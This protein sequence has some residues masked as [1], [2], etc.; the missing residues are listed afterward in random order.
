MRILLHILAINYHE[1]HFTDATAPLR[2]MLDVYKYA[3]FCNPDFVRRK[4]LA[5]EFTVEKIMV[6]LNFL[7]DRGIIS[8]GPSTKL[9]NLNDL[10]GNEFA[11]YIQHC[12]EE[13]YSDLNVK[14]KMVVMANFWRVN[15]QFPAWTRLAQ[16]MMLLQPTS[17]AAERAFS[18][19]VRL[20]RRPGMD[21]AL[22]DNIE[23]TLMLMYNGESAAEELEA[24]EDDEDDDADD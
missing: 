18:R 15:R 23:A 3:R 5:R 24:E 14:E 1:S 16:H 12:T 21:G 4:N 19:L 13:D 8:R 10:I 22:I 6:G 2:P 20:L 17:A 7:A 11:K 9:A